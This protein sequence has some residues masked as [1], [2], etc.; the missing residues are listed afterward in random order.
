ME[1]Q[2]H[3][4][5]VILQDE[6]LR[7]LRGFIQIPR[8][9]LLHKKLS[10]GAKV[11]YG[12]LLN[13]AWQ[14]DFCYPAQEGIA[15]D[16]NCSVRQA[17][18]FLGELKEAGLISWKQHGLNRPNTYYLLPIREEKTFENKDTTNMSRPD[19]T[20]LSGQD[21]TNMSYYLETYNYNN[22]VKN[23]S[24][25]KKKSEEK[26]T[27]LVELPNL[28]HP[29]DK[30]QDLADEILAEFGDDHSRSFYELVAAKVPERYIRKKM[31]ELRQGSVRNKA[32]VFTHCMTEY[33][34]EQLSNTAR[35]LL[36]EQRKSLADHFTVR[37]TPNKSH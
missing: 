33:A 27:G 9:I 25:K 7:K 31:S 10:Y 14:D 8:F 18:R 16:L 17:Q 1:R 23:V 12:I 36:Q 15:R 13:Y 30:I 32:R 2:Q 28:D 26:Q 11:A 34:R 20:Y 6:G 35:G 21:T 37:T 4:K 3:N 29:P 5:T 22:N 19:T 24:K